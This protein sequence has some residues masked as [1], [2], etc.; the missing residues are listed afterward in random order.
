MRPDHTCSAEKT[1]DVVEASPP[2]ASLPASPLS[3]RS[4]SAQA[5]LAV[6]RFDALLANVC[7]NCRVQPPRPPRHPHHTDPDLCEACDEAIAGVD[8]LF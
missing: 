4:P 6:G 7:F 3:G 5:L 8:F 1:T 2:A